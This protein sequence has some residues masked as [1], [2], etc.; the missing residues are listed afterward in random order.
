MN[1]LAA[2]ADTPYRNESQQ[3]ILT[4]LQ[5]LAGH[6][7]TGIAPSDIARQLEC[8]ASNTTRDLANLRLAG[9]A[10]Q[11]PETGRWRL[12]P[13]VVQIALKHMTALERA[14]ARLDEVRQRFSRS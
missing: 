12:G 3:R 5:I 6:E 1:T 7:I 10:E 9:L 4:T 8:T 13:S 2:P 14:Q 11:V